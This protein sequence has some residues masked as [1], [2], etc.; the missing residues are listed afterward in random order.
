MWTLFGSTSAWA[1]V[2]FWLLLTWV[3]V[4]PPF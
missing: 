1:G 3:V 2:V 4:T